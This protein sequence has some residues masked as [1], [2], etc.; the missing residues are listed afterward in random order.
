MHLREVLS[1]FTK[2]A[3]RLIDAQESLSP[4]PADGVCEPGVRTLRQPNRKLKPAEVEELVRRYQ[5]GISMSGL[6]KEYGMH[7]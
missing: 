1:N 7:L 2:D 4:A 3:R 6:A 5:A